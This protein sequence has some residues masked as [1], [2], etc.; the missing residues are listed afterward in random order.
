MAKY[1]GK[2]GF[3]VQIEKTPGVWVDDIIEKPYSGDLLRNTRN[4][5]TSGNLNDDITLSN[6]ISIIADAYLNNNLF[7]LRY[8]VFMGSK[9][10]VTSVDVQYPRLIF[11]IGGVWNGEPH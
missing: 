10:K 4:T 1:H 5:Q 6:Q 9:W 3:A 7:A 8:I 11:T 2:I